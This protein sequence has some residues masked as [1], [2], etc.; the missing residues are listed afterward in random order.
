MSNNS[1]YSWESFPNANTSDIKIKFSNGEEE[2]QFSDLTGGLISVQIDNSITE[3]L[4]VATLSGSRKYTVQ[5]VPENTEMFYYEYSGS[6]YGALPDFNIFDN[7]EEL[8]I[9]SNEFDSWAGNTVPDSLITCDLSNNQ[10]PSAVVDKLLVAFTQSTSNTGTLDLGG[11][12]EAPGTTGIT[13]ARDLID[14]G[15]SLEVVDGIPPVLFG[16]FSFIVEKGE[17]YTFTSSDINATD[18]DSANNILVFF[19]SDPLNGEVQ[20]SGSEANTFTQQDLYD[21]VVTFLHDDT[22][23]NTA[24]FT[25]TLSDG[26]HTLD[27]QEI[28]G[29]VTITDVAPELTG[30]FAFTVN[31]GASY[32]L[33]SSDLNATDVDTANTNLIF[34]VS[35][36]VNGVI[37]VNGS[38]ANTFTQQDL[39]DGIVSYLHD[40]SE[41]ITGGFTVELTDGVNTLSTQAITATITPVDDDPILTGDFAFT[42][43]EGGTYV[44]TS[45]DLNATDID[46]ANTNLVYTVSDLVNGVVQVSSSTANTFT[47]QDLYDGVV[48]YVHDGSETT[49]GAFTVEL[50]DGTNTLATQVI[51]ATVT[52]VNDSPELTGDFAFTV[53]EGASYTLTSSDILATDADNANTELIFTVSDLVN[54]VVQVNSSDAN[55]FTQQDIFDGIVSYLHDGSETTSGSFTIELT[56]GTETLATQVV[57]ATVTPSDDAPILAGDFAFT[58]SE[59]GTYTLTSSDLLATDVDTANTNLVFT[60]T[61]PVNGLVQLSG[62]NTSS[63]TQQDIFDGVV[64]YVHDG[65]ETTSG[66][67]TVELT[68]GTSTLSTQVI[69][70]T[71]TPVDDAPILT[72]DFEFTVDEQSVYIFTTSDFNATDNDLDANTEFVYTF[73][74]PTAGEIEVDGDPSLTATQADLEAGIV[75][76][77]NTSLNGGTDSFTVTADNNSESSSAPET[78]S[79]TINQVFDSAPELVANTSPQ[80][81]DEASGTR[82]YDVSP[83]VTGNNLVWLLLEA[84]DGVTINDSTGVIS[85]DANTIPVELEYEVVYRAYN[86]GGTVENSYTFVINAVN[87]FPLFPE[88]GLTA[89]D[90]STPYDPRDLEDTAYTVGGINVTALT[91]F[92]NV[93]PASINTSANWHRFGL[94]GI[95]MTSGTTYTICVAIK[96]IDSGKFRLN[97]QND[98]NTE[99]RIDY[100]LSDDSTSTSGTAWGTWEDNNRKYTGQDGTTYYLLDYTPS[101]TVTSGRLMIGT[102]LADTSA[103]LIVYTLAYSEAVVDDEP[104]SEIPTKWMAVASTS[105][106]SGTGYVYGTPNSSNITVH[107]TKEAAMAAPCDSIQTAIDNADPGTVILVKGGINEENAINYGQAKFNAFNSGSEGNLT[108]LLCDTPYGARIQGPTSGSGENSA[109]YNANAHHIIVENFLLEVRRGSVKD[110]AA[111]KVVNSSNTGSTPVNHIYLRGCKLSTNGGGVDVIKCGASREIYIQGCELETDGFSQSTIDF[112]SVMRGEISNCTATGEAKEGIAIKGGSFGLTVEKNIIDIT[113]KSGKN[114]VALLAGEAGFSRDNRDIPHPPDEFKWAEFFDSVIRYNSFTTDFDHCLWF[115]GA[116]NL[117]LYYNYFAGHTST[118]GEMLPAHSGFFQDQSG[119]GGDY[120]SYVDV[121][122]TSSGGND[123]TYHSRFITMYD[124]KYQN[125]KNSSISEENSGTNSIEALTSDTNYNFIETETGETIGAGGW[126]QNEIYSRYGLIDNSPELTG[127]FAFTVNRGDSYTLTSSDLNATDVDTANT[128]LIYTVSDLVNGSVQVSGSNANTFTQQDLYDGVVTY[129]HDDTNTTTGSFDVVLSDGTTDLSAQTISAT[130][131]LPFWEPTTTANTVTLRLY[132]PSETYTVNFD[133]SVSGS[134]TATLG[135]DSDVATDISSLSGTRTI[136][137]PASGLLSDAEKF[138]CNDNEIS[139]DLPDFSQMT[140]LIDFRGQ[141]NNFD[142]WEGNSVPSTLVDFECQNNDLDE[143]TVDALLVAFDDAGS[144]SGIL[145]LGGTNAPPSAAGQAAK[146][147]LEGKGWTVTVAADTSIT[148]TVDNV[149]PNVYYGYSDGSGSASG[150]NFSFG[151][152]TDTNIE[153]TEVVYIT[154]QQTGRVRISLTGHTQKSGVSLLTVTFPGL[155]E[156]PLS[157]PWNGSFYQTT[158]AVGDRGTYIAGEQ[159]NELTITITQS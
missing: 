101:E 55:T 30:D 152:G 21:G 54:G 86:S 159:G 41:T 57:T 105:G 62:A 6:V 11:N 144:S 17:S 23:T 107:S 151:T 58:V 123:V 81:W 157:C 122:G 45:S 71:I 1:V 128:S 53:G 148:I 38:T 154:I 42:V 76:Y 50:T 39:Y 132:I 158:D 12:N 109:V 16:D 19:V 124:N 22:E 15:W 10:L 18:Y 94:D 36:L 51:T 5:N 99:H 129:L 20:V 67:F 73:S 13:A 141:D 79:V 61:S 43:S 100:T 59:G 155:A 114:S 37:R 91:A 87:T 135:G 147:S 77:K 126:D 125:G 60:V 46:T 115:R 90:P 110:D 63:F 138:Y 108:H 3:P 82:T 112:V 47:Q 85:H 25:I 7:L 106:D 121:P 104:G 127:D 133:G 142:G 84:P 102:G 145:N 117:E 116:A 69:S 134:N 93:I 139:G 78:I 95:T 65:S 56:D 120:S 32:T 119:S 137:F 9:T 4:N 140:S 88:I 96:D 131:L 74:E 27:P 2:I 89:I 111:F 143:A 66:S 80:S 52:P 149:G 24:G 153:G 103:D 118:L 8:I 150:S 97:V 75:K 49:S 70:A 68:D 156:G 98:S 29:T 130:V 44:I 136:E 34:S 28:S 113:T 14:R 40:G 31:E 33:T 146:T 83:T 72:G 92:Q 35:D 48:T 26:T 64:T